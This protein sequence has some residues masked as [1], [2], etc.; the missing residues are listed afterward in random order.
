MAQAPTTLAELH[1]L[2]E[3]LGTVREALERGPRQIKTRTKRV[4]DAEAAVAAAE[5]ELKA[6]KSGV[7]QKNLE[8]KTRETK[9]ADLKGKLNQASS[10]KEFDAIRGQIAADE[11]AS[12]V[13]EDE[14]LEAI[15]RQEAAEAAVRDSKEA[16]TAAESELSA[17]EKQFQAKADELTARAEDLDRTASDADTLVPAALR[18]QYKRL[19]ESMGADGLAPVEDGTCTGCY[20]QVTPQNRVLLNGGE[21]M[22]CRSCNRLLYVAKASK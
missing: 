6:R 4:T 19:R 5:E 2:L 17:T 22:F 10:N 12:G 8:L 1:A 9:I 13:L 16:V 21:V 11:T 7:N 20:V 3:E 15:D 14:V 18:D